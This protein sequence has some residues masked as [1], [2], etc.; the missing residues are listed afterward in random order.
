MF[1][2]H[3]AGQWAGASLAAL[4]SEACDSQRPSGAQA[5][6]RNQSGE[7]VEEACCGHRLPRQCWPT[8]TTGPS[9]EGRCEEAGQRQPGVPQ[10]S[11]GSVPK[12]KGHRL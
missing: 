2:S 4:P 6:A 9:E 12:K 10:E 5:P 1:L 7:E 3:L 11:R 8:L